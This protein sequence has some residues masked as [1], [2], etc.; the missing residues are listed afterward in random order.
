MGF[1]GGLW[2]DVLDDRVVLGIQQGQGAM[3]CL[4]TSFSLVAIVCPLARQGALVHATFGLCSLGLCS[5]GLGQVLGSLQLLCGLGVLAMD[6]QT[7]CRNGRATR[8]QARRKSFFQPWP[9]LLLVKKRNEESLRRPYTACI[10]VRSPSWQASR[11][12]SELH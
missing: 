8:Q 6:M 7:C 5:S 12:S 2:A 11:G 4:S 1:T 9:L 3:L 10:K